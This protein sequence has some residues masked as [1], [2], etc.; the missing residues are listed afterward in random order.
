MNLAMDDVDDHGV[1]PGG[2][3]WILGTLKPIDGAFGRF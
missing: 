2:G 1:R 3:C